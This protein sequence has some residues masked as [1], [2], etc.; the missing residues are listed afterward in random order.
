MPH[1]GDFMV[2]RTEDLK[3]G[4]IYF[5]V[6][7]YTEHSEIPVIETWIYIGKNLSPHDIKKGGRW[8][9]QDPES[10]VKHGSFRKFRRKMRHHRYVV[11]EGTAHALFSMEGLSEALKLF[12]ADWLKSKNR[13]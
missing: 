6:T 13:T 5:H 9:F 4:E 10:Y 8:Y 3:E 12:N 7:Y 11:D 2:N 1:P